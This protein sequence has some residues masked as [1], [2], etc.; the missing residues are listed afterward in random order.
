MN[1]DRKSFQHPEWSYQSN[2]YEVNLRQYTP[3]GT[4]AAFAKHLPRLR[5]MGVEILWFMPVTPISSEGRLGTLG[6]YYAVKDYKAVNP[7]YG[8]LDDFKRLVSQA[9]QLGFKVIVDFV[10]NHTGNDH[11]WVKEHPDF[12]CYE[13][14]GTLLHPHGWIDTAQLNFDN[15]NVWSA[16]IDAMCFWITECDVDGFRCDMAHLVPLALWYEARVALSDLKQDIFMLAECEVPAYHQVFDATYT[17]KFMH[18]MEDFYHG[19]LSLE[20]MLM[21][22]YSAAVE[23][24]CTAF[25]VHFTSNHDENSWNGTEYE[26]YGNAALLFA[27]LS[28]TWNGLPMI[29]SGQEMP[30]LKRLKFFEK[31]PIEWTGDFQLHRFYQTLLSLRRRNPSLRAGDDAATT[32]IISLPHEPKV[33]SYLRKNGDDAVLVVLNCSAEPVDFQLLNISGDYTNIFSGEKM[34]FTNDNRLHLLP[35]GY[36][37]FEK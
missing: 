37:I 32:T 30:N 22:L 19:R 13:V 17:W 7:E 21:V 23:F 34:A 35:W 16:L 2:I 6:S 8:D 14:D 18:A 12:Y 5:D 20:R 33:F 9:H 36:M 27:V 29:Y 31:D 25:R 1:K 26:K 4:F 24:P 10:A 3:E 15:K 28:C 11:H